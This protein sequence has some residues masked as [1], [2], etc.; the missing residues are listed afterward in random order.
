VAI[1]AD[2]GDLTNTIAQ[3]ARSNGVAPGTVRCVLLA[4]LLDVKDGVSIRR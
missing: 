1:V 3:I 2:A 4:C